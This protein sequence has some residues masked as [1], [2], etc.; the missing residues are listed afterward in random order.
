MTELK[1]NS[2]PETSGRASNT[3]RRHFVMTLCAGLLL[4]AL[5]VGLNASSKQD[6]KH[7]SVNSIN[8]SSS[9]QNPS[10]SMLGSAPGP[11]PAPEL[12]AQPVT[13]KKQLKHRSPTVT[14]VDSTYGVSF[15][16]PRKFTLK[17]G[18]QAKLESGAAEQATKFIEPGEVMLARLELPSALYKGTDFVYGFFNVSV[19]KSLSSEQCGQFAAPVSP[20]GGDASVAEGSTPEH[21]EST[22]LV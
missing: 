11:L 20:A 16:Y 6:S 14:Y 9:T 19:N 17:T 15:T 5:F 4:V 12:S 13:K 21:A 8:P 3:D 1:L 22:P 7:A 2:N 10:G 18:E